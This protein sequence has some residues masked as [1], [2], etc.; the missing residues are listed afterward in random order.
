MYFDKFARLYR[1]LRKKYVSRYDVEDLSQNYQIR[2]RKKYVSEKFPPKTI[3]EPIFD[4]DSI[5]H[6]VVFWF[7]C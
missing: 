7:F 3:R 4:E 2:N 6:S 1:N 5:V